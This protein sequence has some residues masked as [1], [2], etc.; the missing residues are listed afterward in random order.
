MSDFRDFTLNLG[1]WLPF[2]PNR[3]LQPYGRYR[4]RRYEVV[5]IDSLVT[6]ES[7]EP[8]KVRIHS[9]FSFTKVFWVWALSFIQQLHFLEGP[10]LRNSFCMSHPFRKPVIWVV[11]LKAGFEDAWLFSAKQ[12][13]LISIILHASAAALWQ[14]EKSRV[15]LT[16]PPGRPIFVYDSEKSLVE[17]AKL[18][19]ASTCRDD[20]KL[21]SQ[22]VVCSWAGK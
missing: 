16:S 19:R 7:S 2:P 13:R 5:A 8:F 11:H 18:S 10:H 1:L 15:I 14:Y 22:K 9:Y 6:G 20:D 17:Q 3:L 21:V 12:K 4:K